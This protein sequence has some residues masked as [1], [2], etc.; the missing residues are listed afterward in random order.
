[1]TFNGSVSTLGEN[2][3]SEVEGSFVSSFRRSSTFLIDF[4]QNTSN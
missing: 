4:D 2:Q 1:M 3:G